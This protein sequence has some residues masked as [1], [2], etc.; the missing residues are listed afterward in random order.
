MN[1]YGKPC[2]TCA[3]LMGVNG[4]AY[5]PCTVIEDSADDV[6]RYRVG[7]Y[8]IA[9]RDSTGEVLQTVGYCCPLSAHADRNLAPWEHTVGCEHYNAAPS[10][11][12][13]SG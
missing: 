6:T 12:W 10:E 8:K 9:I 5:G 4:H 1:V 7:P 2:P 11:G 3:R 13:L